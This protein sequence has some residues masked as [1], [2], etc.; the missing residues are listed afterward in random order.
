MA[1]PH[2]D[3]LRHRDHLREELARLRASIDRLQAHHDEESSM[4]SSADSTLARQEDRVDVGRHEH[5]ALLE[6]YRELSA[7]AA[8]LRGL[9][10]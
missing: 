4:R 9:L 8:R 10:P 3:L 7:E 1:E 6:R 5:D 2:A